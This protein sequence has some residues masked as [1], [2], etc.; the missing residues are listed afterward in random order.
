MK[1]SSSTS[2]GA[3]ADR[4]RAG[5]TDSLFGPLFSSP[6]V[7][8]EL[9][10]TAWVQAMLD[11]ESALAGALAD[12]EL[13]PR[14]AAE[15]IAR[16]CVVTEFDVAEIAT[17]S[18]GA[19]NPVVPMVSALTGL[20]PADAAG[21]VH[22][23]ATSQD[24]LDTATMLVAR[25]AAVPLFAKLDTVLA[26][27]AGLAGTHRDTVLAGR[28]LGQQA[29]PTTF[30][31]T[32]A[33]WLTGL[34]A[35]VGRLSTVVESLPAQLGGAAGTLASLGRHGIPVARAFAAR[36]GLVEPVLPWHTLRGPVVDLATALGAVA[37]ALGKIATDVIL[38]AQTEVAE[39]AEPDGAGG[40]STM[41][42]KHNP[43]RAITALAGVRRTP[44]LVATVLSAMPAEHERATSGW[45][46]EW[47]P[48][49]ELLDLLGGSA[50]RLAELTPGLRVDTDR[51]RG[52][53]D[54]TNGLLLAENVTTR[55]A[56][57]LG[58]LPAHQLVT[59]LARRAGRTGRG[60]REILAEDSRI[61]D[62]L[63]AT[64]LDAALDPAGYLGVA[65]EFVDRALAAYEKGR[66]NR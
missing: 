17:R 55:L 26:A 11:A 8:A 12:V 53:L 34:D 5:V 23:G 21:F 54:L 60:L 3:G 51:M 35:A 15:A 43:I 40:S 13:I 36:L 1:P 7:A 16:C 2:E 39:L 65:G 4:A 30:G 42:H 37:G 63:P 24:I 31:L 66:T 18:L 22:K 64:E 33:G 45:H 6:A 44:G 9:T 48:L 29:V 57:T 59:E 50:A 47:E 19:G 27:C 49:R 25:R 58:R 46:L 61:T 28:T 20:V 62:V 32:A 14:A 41:P 10:A 52:N 56:G 38:F